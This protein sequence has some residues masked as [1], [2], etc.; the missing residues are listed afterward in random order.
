MIQKCLEKLDL[1]RVWRKQEVY[2]KIKGL[3][4]MEFM[5]YLG[6]GNEGCLV[7]TQFDHHQGL[8]NMTEK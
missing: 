1:L 2:V 8:Q 7:E 6:L 4:K 3:V 5:T